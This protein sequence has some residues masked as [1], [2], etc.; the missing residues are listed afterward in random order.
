MF[1]FFL[2]SDMINIYQ[3]LHGYTQGLGL[4][5]WKIVNIQVFPLAMLNAHFR[6]R[7]LGKK[8]TNSAEKLKFGSKIYLVNPTDNK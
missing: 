7:G 5:L 6:I 1:I 3:N 2:V 8:C 4:C